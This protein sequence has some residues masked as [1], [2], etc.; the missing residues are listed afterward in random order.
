MEGT[1]EFDRLKR[2]FF[3]KNYLDAKVFCYKFNYSGVVYDYIFS[4]EKDLLNNFETRA[5]R[6]VDKAM[7]SISFT[8]FAKKMPML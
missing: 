3:M 7:V 4:Y 6:V 5:W 8:D 1:D 2:L